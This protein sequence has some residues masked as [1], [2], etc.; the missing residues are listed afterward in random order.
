MVVYFLNAF[1]V[2]QMTLPKC[3]VLSSDGK[4]RM[5]FCFCMIFGFKVCQDVMSYKVKK[6]GN[7]LSTPK[8]FI[9]KIFSASWWPSV[10]RNHKEWLLIVASLASGRT[11]KVKIVH[12]WGRFKG[13]DVYNIN[14]ALL[15]ICYCCIQITCSQKTWVSIIYSWT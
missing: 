15:Y 13:K 5:C 9:R 4:C 14:F 7:L 1:L 2:G 11:A 6:L 12:S 3:V 10:L 8:R